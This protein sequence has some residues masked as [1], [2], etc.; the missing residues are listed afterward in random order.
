MTCEGFEWEIQFM[1]R[2]EP[3]SLLVPLVCGVVR[4]LRGGYFTTSR[5]YA[6]T[7]GQAQV[8]NLKGHDSVR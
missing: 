5:L 1:W 2:C 3:S 8:N 6:P 4:P 7:K